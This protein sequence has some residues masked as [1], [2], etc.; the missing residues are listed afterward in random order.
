MATGRMVAVIGAPGTRRLAA[1]VALLIVA[2]CGDGGDVSVGAPPADD[3]VP[4][5]VR[6]RIEQ[7]ETGW[8]LCPGG[9][10]PCWEVVD[11]GDLVA[12]DVV[13]EGAW[14]DGRIRLTS[15]P[16][17]P[18]PHAVTRTFPNPCPDAVGM[19]GENGDQSV[20]DR[21][22]AYGERHRD[23]FA[24]L[25]LARPGPVVV[26]AFTAAAERHRA[27][28]DHPSI[29][30][31]DEGFR[32]PQAELE[33]I[34]REIGE[35]GWPMNSSGIDTL[36]NVVTISFDTIDKALEDQIG[37]RWGDRVRVDAMVVVLEGGA[38]RLEQEPSPT[39]IPILTGRR[40]AASMHALGRFTLRY[41]DEG[42]CIY[43]DG[44]DGRITP[45]WRHGT[46]ALRDP[47]RVVNGEGEVIARV[48]RPFETGGGFTDRTNRDDPRACGG[49]GMW[50]M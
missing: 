12:A 50:V 14:R 32:Y 26:V 29:C 20:L 5:R 24:G 4:V 45:V 41:D 15:E 39:E 8:R 35:S 21:A 49:T 1:L 44:S 33:A 31:T 7:H 30:V 17:T 43:L 34:Q 22:T 13:V 19:G 37:R 40:G 11:G 9:A 38:E 16:E 27:A 6:G 23:Q 42:D 10:A 48:D 47:V 25:W 28:L 18:P 3:W 46:K 36:G 2:G